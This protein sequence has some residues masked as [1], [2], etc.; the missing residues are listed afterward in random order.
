MAI[1]IIHFTSNQL[2]RHGFRGLIGNDEK[3]KL[4]DC[5]LSDDLMSCLGEST[6]LVVVNDLDLGDD[7]RDLV[8]DIRDQS[9]TTP[10]LLIA[11]TSE[12]GN[13]L[14]AVDL[15]VNGFLTK[16]CDSDEII[17]SVHA[18]IKG[19]RFFCNNVLNILLDK[20]SIEEEEDCTPT[21]LSERE[22]EITQH[23]A[24]GLTSRK[25][26]DKL[27]I[28]PHTVQTHRKNIMRKLKVNSVSELVVY[29]MKA[30]L[31]E[32]QVG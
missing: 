25:I 12:S 16:E 19:E 32:E 18:L 10:I 9:A 11:D 15:G 30:G 23:I 2:A 21:T 29:A 4:K 26:A 22:V 17:H 5:S 20:S 13:V 24:D 28:S 31:V 6:S 27:F 1:E 3:Y 14:K 7:L 8:V